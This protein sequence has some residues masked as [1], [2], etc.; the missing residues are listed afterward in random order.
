M[1]TTLNNCKTGGKRGKYGMERGEVKEN[2]HKQK[3]SIHMEFTD[4]IP[5]QEE[6]Q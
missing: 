5:T 2:K 4:P 1:A 3:S 6:I